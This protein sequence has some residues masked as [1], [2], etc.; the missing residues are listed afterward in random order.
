M[1]YNDLLWFS[2][3]C[4]LRCNEAPS[5]IKQVA[6]DLGAFGV[7]FEN[8]TKP[9]IKI[10]SANIV[11]GS[12]W[13]GKWAKNQM[14]DLINVYINICLYNLCYCNLCCVIYVM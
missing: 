4:A 10:A 7:R 11:A 13:I 3:K 14:T 9:K 2:N 12:Q 1:E 8:L 6:W 5:Y